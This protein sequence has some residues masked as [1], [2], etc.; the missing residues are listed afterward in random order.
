MKKLNFCTIKLDQILTMRHSNKN[1]LGYIGV[2]N[3]VAT[4]SKTLFVRAA[5][6]VENTLISGKNCNA[7]LS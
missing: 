6:K 1:R 3:T 5:A 2:T 4:M 7:L